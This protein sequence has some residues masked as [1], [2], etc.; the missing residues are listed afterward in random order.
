[1]AAAG[2]AVICLMVSPL[3]LKTLNTALRLIRRAPLSNRHVLPARVVLKLAF[4]AIIALTF[5]GA[6][7]ALVLS[8]FVDLNAQQLIATAAIFNLAGAAGTAAVP[9]PSGI[10]VREAVLISLLHLLVPVDIAIAATVVAR[11]TS[12]L[13]DAGLGGAGFLL[14]AARPRRGAPASTATVGTDLDWSAP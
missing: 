4:F 10:G 11:F 13:T 9:I 5:N 12:L 14:F 1:V 7:F 8:A 2:I 3:L 6:S